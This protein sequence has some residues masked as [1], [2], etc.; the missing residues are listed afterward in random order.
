MAS[1]LFS[2]ESVTE[3]H[4]DPVSD[5][6]LDGWFAVDLQRRVACEAV[7]ETNAEAVP[8]AGKP[9]MGKSTTSA[10]A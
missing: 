10:R 4:S 5:A 3:D 9:G 2:S 7:A 1:D 6:V 8:A